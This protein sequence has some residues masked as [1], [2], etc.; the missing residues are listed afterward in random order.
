MFEHIQRWANIRAAIVGVLA[1][2]GVLLR[3]QP[4][5]AQAT[6]AFVQVNSA[7]PQSPSALEQPR[8]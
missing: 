4:V 1:L 6:I 2:S 7:T 5:F 3:V 8:R